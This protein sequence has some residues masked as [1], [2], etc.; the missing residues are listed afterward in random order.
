[1]NKRDLKTIHNKLTRWLDEPLY[2]A[3]EI[4]LLWLPFS[5][6]GEIPA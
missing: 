2:R 4:W 6:G 1:M 5:F 3:A